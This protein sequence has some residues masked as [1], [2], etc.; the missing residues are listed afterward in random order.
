MVSTRLILWLSCVL[1]GSPLQQCRP[2]NGRYTFHFVVQAVKQSQGSAVC[3]R[4]HKPS[5][6]SSTVSFWAG[7]VYPKGSCKSHTVQDLSLLIEA[8]VVLIFVSRRNY[9][10]HSSAT[11]LF[12][13]KQA[14]DCFEHCKLLGGRWCTTRKD[15]ARAILFKTFRC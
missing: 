1:S 10:Y 12:E 6:V 13:L 11:R 9:Q 4:E 3:P 8:V 14:L 7:L 5:T 2:L 15:P